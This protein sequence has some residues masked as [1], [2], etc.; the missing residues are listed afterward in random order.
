LPTCRHVF[1]TSCID[2][3]FKAKIA[4]AVHKCPLCNGEISIEK[5]KEALIKR[6]DDRIKAKDV[7]GKSS[8]VKT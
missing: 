5:V 1:H 3:W 4:D 7:V 2:G 8:T 6:R